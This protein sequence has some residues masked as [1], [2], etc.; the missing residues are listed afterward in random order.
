MTG[1]STPAAVRTGRICQFCG[2]K[3]APEQSL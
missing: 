3:A 1:L 2:E